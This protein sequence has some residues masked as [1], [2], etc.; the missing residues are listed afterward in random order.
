MR[1][2]V[3]VQSEEVG[4][5]ERPRRRGGG[6]GRAVGIL[7]GIEED[8]CAVVFVVAF[9]R[10]CQWRCDV[11]VGLGGEGEVLSRAA[12]GDEGED[13]RPRARLEVEGGHVFLR[14]SRRD[15]NDPV[16]SSRCS[17]FYRFP[18]FFCSLYPRNGREG[19]IWG[20]T[21]EKRKERGR[22]LNSW[23]RFLVGLSQRFGEGRRTSHRFLADAGTVDFL[24]L[25]PNAP[26]PPLPLQMA[27]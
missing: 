9:A 18:F 21:Q 12:V 7:V 10:V 6:Q 2:R 4:L 8:V 27:V 24:P 23:F 15:R 20:E 14:G 5:A 3:A 26:P 16:S 13:V 25:H 22:F 17:S 19:W 1:V 11:V